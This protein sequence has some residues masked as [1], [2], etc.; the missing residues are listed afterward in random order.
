MGTGD[1]CPCR[2]CSRARLWRVNGHGGQRQVGKLPAFGLGERGHAEA[3]VQLVP[4][5][6]LEAGARPSLQPPRGH[7]SCR[8]GVED[9]DG[10]RSNEKHQEPHGHSCHT[11]LSCFSLLILL[12]SLRFFLYSVFLKF[13]RL[14]PYSCS[15]S[16]IILLLLLFVLLVIS[17]GFPSCVFVFFSFIPPYP[18][19]SFTFGWFLNSLCCSLHVPLWWADNPLFPV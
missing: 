3:P 10:Q 7:A 4:L 2:T 9:E 18:L 11:S 16:R 1:L 12:F 15:S 6:R 8:R 19:N 14:A 13:F 5:Q 17:F